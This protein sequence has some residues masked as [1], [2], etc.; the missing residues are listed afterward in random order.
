[1]VAT[2]DLPS[3]TLLVSSCLF[4]RCFLA[5]SGN[6]AWPRHQNPP[7]RLPSLPS[8]VCWCYTMLQ[9][10]MLHWIELFD[11]SHVHELV[12][13]LNGSDPTSCL[14][15]VLSPLIHILCRWQQ[16]VREM[17]FRLS[18]ILLIFV[19]IP[20]NCSAASQVRSK[21]GLCS[22]SKHQVTHKGLG[23]QPKNRQ[24]VLEHN[25]IDLLI[26]AVISAR[27]W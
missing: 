12:Q 20:Q 6:H 11:V 14:Q 17:L 15:T 26:S 4:L 7:P 5:R 2:P 10:R 21:Q 8:H 16:T 13:T 19:F 24:H 9:D 3:L 22:L 27:L 25:C 1:M 18:F 23:Q